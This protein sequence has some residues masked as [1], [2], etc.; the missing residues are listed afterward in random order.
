MLNQHYRAIYKHAYV[1]GLATVAVGALSVGSANAALDKTTYAGE[2]VVITDKNSAEIKTGDKAG[3]FILG[4]K[5]G[6]VTINDKGSLTTAAGAA[7]H[8]YTE[9]DV[10]LNK[11]ASLTFNGEAGKG[12]GLVGLLPVDGQSDATTV[13]NGPQVGSL[14]ANGGTITLNKSQIQMKNVT[15]DGGTTVTISGDIKTAPNSDWSDMSQITAQGSASE[16]GGILTINKATVELG[17]GSV[18]NGNKIDINDG[19]A[20]TM[21]GTAAA[22]TRSII[23]TYGGGT[24][25][26]NGGKISVDATGKGTAIRSA[27][28]NITG[29]ELAVAKDG[30]LDI[31]GALSG[32]KNYD[33]GDVGAVNL[34]MTGGKID[35]AGT[36]NLGKAGQDDK[37][38]FNDGT[39]ANTGTINLDGEALFAKTEL[40]GGVFGTKDKAGKLV[41]EEGSKVSVNGDVDLTKNGLGFVA[42]GTGNL[43]DTKLA[44]TN[45]ATLDVA[46]KATLGEQYANSL[47]LNADSVDA[48]GKVLLSGD[49]TVADTNLKFFA[50]TGGGNV[51]I[52]LLY[53]SDA[54]DD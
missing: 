51:T 49:F 48:A 34:T 23:R 8:F 42:D 54:A 52:C 20:I 44:V 17:E 50:A 26:L 37:F 11:G 18:L 30:T 46:G 14:T 2:N 13:A 38:A 40:F 35:N 15:L 32:S 33:Q 19:A 22:G 25:N 4:Q 36:L 16:N 41:L 31:A 27:N 21:K 29:T 9:A 10:V 5:G 3:G 39:I 28:I 45:S 47:L 1:L 12:Y 53:T 6:T 24:A 43:T 7:G